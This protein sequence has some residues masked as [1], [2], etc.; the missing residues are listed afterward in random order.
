MSDWVEA[1]LAECQMHAVRHT[2]RLAQL[3]ERLSEHPASRMPTACHG[4]AATMAASRLLHHPASGVQEILS[5]H[6]HATRQRIRAQ[7][8]V[9]LVQDTTFLHDGTPQPPAGMGTVKIKT[10]AEYLLHLTVAFTP[11]RVKGGGAGMKVWPRPAEP[12]AQQRK[13]QPIEEQ[14]SDRWLEGDRGAC[15]IKQ[16][17][18]ATLG[19]NR[20]DRAGDIQE[21]L[22]DARRREPPQRAEVS[23]RAKGN[24]RLA[25]GAAQ[26]Y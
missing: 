26:R 16:P 8:G 10:R 17:C 22:V 12:G 25:P 14:A 24:R 6:T 18:P 3:F 20:A 19:V 2:R 21:W 23:I 9:W 11:E 13:S 15:E 1:E 5:G 4:W 7:E